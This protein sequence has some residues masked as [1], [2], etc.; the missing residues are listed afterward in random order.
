MY[1]TISGSGQSALAAHSRLPQLIVFCNTPAGIA[2]PQ[3]RMGLAYSHDA[4]SLRLRAALA[5]KQSS[6]MLLN[7]GPSSDGAI[8][9]CCR[10]NCI[11][12]SA[13]A[14]ASSSSASAYLFM[15]YDSRS[16]A[17]GCDVAG[18]SFCACSRT[19]RARMA[20][21]TPSARFLRCFADGAFSKIQSVATRSASFSSRAALTSSRAG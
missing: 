5:K 20:T 8:P 13:N 12:Q 9:L 16:Y 18:G 15:Q 19:S 21:T 2:S 11:P 3:R 17:L 6:K 1:R 10:L 4:A 7:D 14:K